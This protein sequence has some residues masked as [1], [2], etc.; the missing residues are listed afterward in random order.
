MVVKSILVTHSVDYDKEFESH[1]K[2]IKQVRNLI[3][4]WLKLNVGQ[5]VLSSSTQ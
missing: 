4:F 5:H 3:I 1:H 2:T